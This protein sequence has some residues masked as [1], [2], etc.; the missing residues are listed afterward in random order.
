M[1]VLSPRLSSQGA[2]ASATVDLAAPRAVNSASGVLY[3]NITPPT[4]EA[5]WIVPHR[6]RLWRYPSGPFSWQDIARAVQAAVPDVRL[7]LILSAHW[8]YPLN[9]WNGHGAPWENWA[10]YEEYIRNVARWLRYVGVTGTLEVWNEPDVPMFWNGTRDQFHETYARAYQVMRAELGPDAEIGGPNFGTYDHATM[11][12]FLEFCLARGC[13]VNEL[14]FHA[15]DD[16]PAQ[17][18][19]IPANV[20]DAQVSFLENPRY[21][22]LRIRRI[23]I[24]EIVGPLYTHQ[25]AGTLAYYAAFE[26]SGAALAARSC[27]PENFAEGECYGT[28]DGLLTPG[29]G[30]P[31]PRSVW[32]AHSLYAAGVPS[33]VAATASTANLVVLGS[34]GSP[35]PPQ[36]LIGH[37]NFPRTIDRQPAT[38]V[39]QLAMNHVS[40]L[41]A[42]AAAP[43]AQVQIE[44]IPNSGEAALAAPVPRASYPARIINGALAI[45]LPAM[46][47]GEV[48]RVTL[49]PL[50]NGPP[51]PPEGFTAAVADNAVS[52]R[53]SAPASGPSPSGYVLE[54]GSAPDTANLLQVPLGAV[55]SFDA[56]AP[57]GTYYVR[58]R[59]TNA[60]GAGAPTASLR[61]D[62]GCVTPPGSPLG[63]QGQMAGSSVTLAWQRGSGNVARYI[64]EAGSAAGLRNIASLSLA[65][66]PTTFAAAATP[67][68]YYV[69]VRAANN[70]GVGPPSAEVSL[71]VG[72]GSEL[73]GPPGTPSVVVSGSTVSLSWTAPALGSAPTAYRLEA[74]TSPGLANAALVTLGTTPS[75][76]VGGVP[77]GIYYVRVRAMNPAGV[78]PPSADATVV[79]P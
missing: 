73:P 12:A 71:V 35:A 2:G 51:D 36:V 34:A 77:R 28:L 18:A 56:S 49:Q 38:L 61:V 8:G 4:R 45:T 55:T 42:F 70:C 66:A 23:I 62:A 44:S 21:A 5:A 43:F 33:R 7:N 19:A 14:L 10:A 17:I 67:G 63:L 60:Y 40:A 15:L 39:A 13:E 72:T 16:Q 69:R 1:S 79:V 68:T 54:A 24:N 31:Q 6:P 78:G 64:L 53:W 29:T 9:N 25:P 47:V 75:Y 48:L 30:P 26:A 52:L 20:R 57:T 65:P 3:A 11:A 74:G 27:W 22:P 46:Q 59:S 41:P 37:V 58:M 32:W 50:E 76:S